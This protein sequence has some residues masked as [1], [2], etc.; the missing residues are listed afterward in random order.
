MMKIFQNAGW[1]SRQAEEAA[2][3][4]RCP[5]GMKQMVGRDDA[6]QVLSMPRATPGCYAFS[7]V[8]HAYGQGT[9]HSADCRGEGVAWGRRG[10]GGGGPHAQ[11]RPSILLRRHTAFAR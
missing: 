4:P 8:M 1:Q 9:A 10:G 6:R 7:Q 11:A 2:Y 3:S 5:E